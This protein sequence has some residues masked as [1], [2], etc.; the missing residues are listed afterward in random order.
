MLTDKIGNKV[1][2]IAGPTAVGKTELAIRLAE[3]LTGEIISTD[4]RLL[5]RGMDIGTAKPTPAEM[6]RVPHHLI[7]LAEPDEVWSLALFKK[8]LF[9]AI[10]DVQQ[11]NKLPI[12]AGGTGQY[13]RSLVE[14]WVIPAVTPS[15]RLR[16]VL[17]EW[18]KQIG[19][20][21]LHQKLSLI[22]PQAGS[23]ID[24]NNLR[25]TVRALEVIFST[26]ELFSLQKEKNPPDLDFKIIGLMRPRD[27]LYT[28]VDVRIETMFEQGLVKEVEAL[29][30]RGYSAETPTLSAIGYREVIQYLAGRCTLEEAKVQM[31]R[32]TREFI[33]RQANWFKPTDT[34]I[35]WFSMI[36]D[37]LEEIFLLIKVWLSEEH[38]D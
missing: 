38:Y 29:L 7:D 16:E 23:K 30:T 31:R 19:A 28:R 2:I 5:Y 3:K 6:A 33:R 32:K 8:S 21:A 15:P 10:N 24:T 18:G 20:E 14:G 36:P 9:S 27:E 1:V 22:D 26:G 17:E 12:I 37:P 35:E 11:R 34:T 4:S 13:I 25:R